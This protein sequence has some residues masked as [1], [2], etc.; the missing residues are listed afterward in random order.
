MS[1]QV[2]DPIMVYGNQIQNDPT[3]VEMRYVPFERSNVLKGVK[4]HASCNVIIE[5]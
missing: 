5:V 2:V 4:A 1:N 3:D